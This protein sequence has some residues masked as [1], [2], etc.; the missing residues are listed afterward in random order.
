M[1]E[2]GFSPDRFSGSRTV[3]RNAA[4]RASRPTSTMSHFEYMLLVSQAG[5]APSTGSASP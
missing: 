5:R 1:T 4:G 2:A 3:E